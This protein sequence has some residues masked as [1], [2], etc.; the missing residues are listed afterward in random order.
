[1]CPISPI[2]A[3]RSTSYLGGKKK[4]RRSDGQPEL[5]FSALLF[6]R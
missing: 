5:S 2:W 3:W 1:M 6:P 4:A